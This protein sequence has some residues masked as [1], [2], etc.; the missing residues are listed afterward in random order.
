MALAHLQYEDTA[1]EQCR[2]RFDLGSNRY[3]AY[4]I[5]DGATAPRQGIRI[6]Q[7]RAHNSKVLG[8]LEESSEGRG[9]L[10]IPA[11][12]FNRDNR[13]VQLI[14]FRKRDRT[15]PAVS[16]TITLDPGDLGGS[17]ELPEINFSRSIIPMKACLA[18]AHSNGHSINAGPPR[19]RRVRA[20]VRRVR[21]LR[22]LSQAQFFDFGA[23]GSALLSVLPQLIPSLLP[24]FGVSN[25]GPLQGVLQSVLQ[26][27]KTVTPVAPAAP[28]TPLT[29]TA[30]AGGTGAKAAAQSRAQSFARQ[31]R[32]EAMI[33]P[34]LLAA[35]PAL[36]PLLQ[37]VLSPQTIQGVLQIADPN[38]LIGTVTQGITQLGQLGAQIQQQ[39]MQHLERINPGV[40]DPALMQLLSTMSANVRE[41]KV[42]HRRV[43]AV[44][45]HFEEIT[46]LSLEGRETPVF[47]RG[48]DWAFPLS[49]ET[50]KPVPPGEL[51]LLIKD[52]QTL[53]VIARQRVKTPPL[54]SGKLSIVN[55]IPADQLTKIQPGRDYLA[56]V[57]LLWK[58][59]SGERIGAS[60]T[61]LFTAADEFTFDGLEEAGEV[62]PLN[63]VDKFRDFWHEAWTEN[64]SRELI[65]LELECQY[66]FLF[67]P[68]ELSNAHLAT[69]T[70]TMEKGLRRRQGKVESG[71]LLSPNRLNELLPKISPHPQLNEKQLAALLTPGFIQQTQTAARTSVKFSGRPGQ[72][73]ALWIYPEVKVKQVLLQHAAQT[74]DH[75]AIV[76]FE[77]HAVHF[78]IPVLAH[79]IGVRS[80]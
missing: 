10:E 42:R 24:A 19:A 68:D 30:P 63:D 11:Q 2:F 18:T 53:N 8:P 60:L 7:N 25:N 45:L 78:P 47:E 50:A 56:C 79:F 38:R 71:V 29:A 46:P 43:P 44:K 17:A 23:I 12:L 66:Y 13:S 34:A 4:A 31:P 5:G 73:A 15:G 41:T 57:Y 48:R 26:G 35:I 40:D 33:A 14:S 3:Y 74:N 28:T 27:L 39:E 32:S 65:R 76:R 37:Q 54:S 64:F 6:L 58:N 16:E 62:I 52:A 72:T 61:Q 1:G 80:R 55:K 67:Q 69:T 22:T 77:P 51:R 75:G 59:K 21:R 70:K 49:L 36:M 9:E 20:R